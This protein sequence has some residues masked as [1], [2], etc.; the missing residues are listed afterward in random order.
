M[1]VNVKLKRSAVPGKIPLT[2][3][4]ELG[5]LAQKVGGKGTGSLTATFTQQWGDADEDVLVIPDF[6]YADVAKVQ[7]AFLG[8]YEQIVKIA[9]QRGK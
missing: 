2:S 1:A 6:S 7:R 8:K 4:L 9:E 5:E 3:S